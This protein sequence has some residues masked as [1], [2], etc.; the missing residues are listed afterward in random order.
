M[1]AY[2]Q[3]ENKFIHTVVLGEKYEVS[4]RFVRG[5]D[6]ELLVIYAD[7]A[8]VRPREANFGLQFVVMLIHV[9]TKSSN[10]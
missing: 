5:A 10:S 1:V 8:N 6:I 4:G 9:Q 2:A 3:V 7:V